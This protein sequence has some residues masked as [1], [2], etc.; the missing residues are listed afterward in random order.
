MPCFSGSVLTSSCCASLVGVVP[1][2]TR[3][4]RG[5]APM[6]EWVFRSMLPPVREKQ[7]K[8]WYRVHDVK[9]HREGAKTRISF[10]PNWKR[11]SLTWYPRLFVSVTGRLS[12][13]SRRICQHFVTFVTF[14]S[15]SHA[16]VHNSMYRVYEYEHYNR[17]STNFRTISLQYHIAALPLTLNETK[18][19]T[20][21]QQQHTKYENV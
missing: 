7:E 12:N 8:H 17:R 13:Y 2:C 1:F 18:K 9:K 16:Y 14:P 11:S 3:A 4:I 20:D 6:W 5:S 19:K 15:M 21:A 10:V